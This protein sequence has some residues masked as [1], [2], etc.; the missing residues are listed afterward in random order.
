MPKATNLGSPASINLIFSGH[1]W[2]T[3]QYDKL[4]NHLLLLEDE[5]LCKSS[6]EEECFL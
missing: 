5:Y 6:L 4:F 2:W 3:V 1:T